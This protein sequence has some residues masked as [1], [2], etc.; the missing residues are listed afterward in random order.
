MLTNEQTTAYTAEALGYIAAN[1]LAG[2]QALRA[3]LAEKI[4]GDQAWQ[5]ATDIIL[6]DIVLL[7]QRQAYATA[8]Q[9]AKDA[10]DAQAVA[11]WKARMNVPVPA[12][13]V[14]AT[15]VTPVAP[16]TYGDHI[17]A[18]KAAYAGPGGDAFDLAAACRYAVQNGLTA[19]DVANTVAQPVGE[20]Q[21][22]MFP[23]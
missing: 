14:Y 8:D 1:P 4:G 10:F 2:Q 9:A 12:A 13:A 11:E 17:E 3:H 23:G 16:K 5:F 6:Q 19:D 18:I 15:T 20:C 21:S 22:L 7:A